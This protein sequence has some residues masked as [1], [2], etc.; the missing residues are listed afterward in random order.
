MTAGAVSSADEDF[1]AFATARWNKLVRSAA[2]L[3]CRQEEAEDL[4]QTTLMRCYVAWNRVS[5]A[6]DPEAYMYRMLFNVRA[7]S[8]RRRWWGEVP[9]ETLPDQ[10]DGCDEFA[11]IDE[12]DAL[13]RAY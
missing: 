11:N 7:D 4:A 2:L 12:A 5:R 13:Q 8:R 10:R 1:T 3:G 9:Y 6:A